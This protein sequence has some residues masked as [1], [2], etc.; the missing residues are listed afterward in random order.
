M[1][2]RDLKEPPTFRFGLGRMFKD[3]M[4][5]QLSEAVRIELRGSDTLNKKSEFSRCRTPRLRVD[6]EVWKYENKIKLTDQPKERNLR[7][8]TEVKAMS[9]V[10]G[11]F[12]TKE[13]WSLRE[14][15]RVS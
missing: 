15:T 13:L 7:S 9:K 8:I 12:K 1:D 3:Q 10:A 6:L 2:H 14:I 11:K 4:T 5:R